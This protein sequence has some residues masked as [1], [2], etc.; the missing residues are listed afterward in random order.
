MAKRCSVDCGVPSAEAT[1]QAS[2]SCGTSREAPPPT[3]ATCFPPPLVLGNL[4]YARAGHWYVGL[5]VETLELK[6]QSRKK[7]PQAS[8]E[9]D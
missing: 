9:G 8:G 2:P 7:P 4:T 1:D 5:A 6:R 3:P